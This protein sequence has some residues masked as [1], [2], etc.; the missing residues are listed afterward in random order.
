MI[1]RIIMLSALAAIGYLGFVR[2]NRLPFN[3]MLVFAI[4]VV[5][6]IAVLFP[7]R[8]D[9]VAN[10]IGVGRGADLIGYLV[11][12]LLLFM[13]LH[14]YTKFVDV[15]RQLTVI[16]RELAILRGEREASPPGPAS[17]SSPTAPPIADA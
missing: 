17:S 12:V 6:G 2:R 9:G 7:E 5:A 13:S 4:L 15:Q 3:I 16:V 14:F 11:Q 8:T 10:W 1:I